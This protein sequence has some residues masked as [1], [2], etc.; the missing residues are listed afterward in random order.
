M[1]DITVQFEFGSEGSLSK[2][3][4]GIINEE[5]GKIQA[6]ILDKPLLIKLDLDKASV[7]SVKSRITE[8]MS[9]FSATPVSGGVV[10]PKDLSSFQSAISSAAKTLDA[11]A[12]S[13]G[14]FGQSSDS[15]VK[16]VRTI[17]RAL[18]NQKKKSDEARDSIKTTNAQWDEIE[19]R[20]QK[21]LAAERAAEN[22]AR[23]ERR[24][25][26]QEEKDRAAA[27][28]KL[29]SLRLDTGVAKG[30]LSRL[31]DAYSQN[32][33]VQAKIGEIAQL[34]KEADAISNTISRAGLDPKA[35]TDAEV[36]VTNLVAKIKDLSKELANLDKASTREN[37]K[38]ERDAEAAARIRAQQVE[39]IRKAEANIAEAKRKFGADD[40]AG[41]KAG[42][43][44]AELDKLRTR[45]VEIQEEMSGP[46]KSL[47][48]DQTKKYAAEIST[49]TTNITA[50]KTELETLNKTSKNSFL[51]HPEDLAAAQGKI[52]SKIREAQ[53]ALTDYSAAEKAKDPDARKAYSNIRNIIGEYESLNKQLNEGSINEEQ[54]SAG[55]KKLNGNLSNYKGT[56]Q[57]LDYDHKTLGD[58]LKTSM[59]KFAQYFTSTRV[60]M[61][62]YRA[63]QQMVRESIAM[64][65]AMTQLQIVTKTSN[66]EMAAYSQTAFES[67]KRL[68]TSVTDVVSATT[69]YARL[70]YTIKESGTLAELT[71]MLQGVGDIDAQSAQSAVTA[72]IKAFNDIDIGNIDTVMDKLV[73]VGNGAPISVAELADGMNNASSALSAAGN[74]FDQTVAL[75]TAANTTIQNAAQ[76]STGLRTISAR[77]RNTTTELD[78]LGETLTSA[79]YDEIVQ[80]LTDITLDDGSKVSVSLT[81]A[82]G[83]LRSTYDIISDIASVWDKMS[84]NQKAALAETLAGTRQQNIFY[85]LVENFGEAQ[86]AMNLMGNSMNAMQD[87][88]DTFLTSTTAHLNQFRAA[89]SELSSDVVNSK[90]MNFLIDRGRNAIEGFDWLVKFSKNGGVIGEGGLAAGLF[91]IGAAIKSIS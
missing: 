17:T 63:M 9:A 88:Y 37:A 77:I 1:P 45:L 72:I 32:V 39:N 34:R 10:N 82:T 5:I 69:T 56:I 2:G 4:T 67:A 19:K 85:S 57:S 38:S 64:N 26:E 20:R 78:E 27:A 47:D 79:E 29:Q 73:A 6:G 60:V 22:A 71:T 75:L 12:K 58:A 87:A 91:G 15:Y 50:L 31:S 43:K 89:F 42:G 13:F 86:N 52:A 25:Q 40:F 83:E 18:T 23:A 68:G 16:Q 41:G 36:K 7:E 90:A 33:N 53:K 24:R 44:I 65:D 84:A 48:L 35:L 54:F 3:V 55:M 14:S 21:S 28:K 11:Y 61:G 80:K 49:I 8:L 74:S 46:N 66:S 51:D 81:D 76:A 30:T 59:S 62:T 70:G